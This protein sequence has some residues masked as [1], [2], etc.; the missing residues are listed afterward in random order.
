MISG[1]RNLADGNPDGK[2]DMDD[3]IAYDDHAR[4][5]RLRGVVDVRVAQHLHRVA[6]LASSGRGPVVVHCADV[7]RL[8]YSALQLL[9]ALERALAKAGDRLCLLEVPAAMER[10]LR[11]AGSARLL[12]PSTAS[13]VALRG[14]DACGS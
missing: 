11:L 8:D 5:I 10:L 2:S 3:D 12:G 14:S 1:K 13:E 7:E 6:M 9:I 4:A